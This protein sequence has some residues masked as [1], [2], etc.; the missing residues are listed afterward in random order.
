MDAQ[1][2]NYKHRFYRLA[3]GTLAFQVSPIILGFG[4]P[5][6]HEEGP[7]GEFIGTYGGGELS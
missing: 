1:A 3:Q 5:M 2:K 6:N 4:I 7:Y